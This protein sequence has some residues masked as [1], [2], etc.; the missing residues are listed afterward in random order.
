VESAAVPLPAKGRHTRH[1]GE[2]SRRRRMDAYGADV[3]AL[4][5]T[6]DQDQSPWL[7]LVD[8]ETGEV[9]QL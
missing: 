1:I 4:K 8:L 9:K 7:G 3:R 6:H 5:S 2:A